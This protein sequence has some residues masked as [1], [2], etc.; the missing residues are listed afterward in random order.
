MMQK[1][2]RNCYLRGLKD[3]IFCL[4]DCVDQI[5]KDVMEE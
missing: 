2:A 4:A 3:G 1:R 5:G